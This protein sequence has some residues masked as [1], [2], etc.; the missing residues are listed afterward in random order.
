MLIIGKCNEVFQLC[1]SW[2]I[3]D[4][5]LYV[6]I[7]EEIN[8][9]YYAMLMIGK[10]NDVFWLSAITRFLIYYQPKQKNTIQLTITF[11]Y[12]SRYKNSGAPMPKIAIGTDLVPNPRKY[13]NNAM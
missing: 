2:A 9:L 4:S 5:N 1:V 13:I 8:C 7:I 10:C 12:D 11:S 3:H 6:N